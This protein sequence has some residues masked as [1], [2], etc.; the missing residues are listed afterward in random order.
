LDLNMPRLD[1]LQ[2]IQKLRGQGERFLPPIIALSADQDAIQQATEMGIRR[3]LA[4]PFDLEVILTLISEE[5]SL[6]CAAA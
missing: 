2:L 6:C 5:S 4:K 3:V 1:G